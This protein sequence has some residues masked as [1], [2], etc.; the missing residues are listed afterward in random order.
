LLPEERFDVLINHRGPD[1]KEGFVKKLDESLRSA[2]IRAFVDANDIDFGHECWDSIRKAIRGAPVCICVFSPRYAESKWCLEELAFILDL[3]K[4]N[5]RKSVLPVF[6]N[7]EPKHLRRPDDSP[8]SEG[9]KKLIELKDISRWRN[10]L[11][12]SADFFGVE[13]ITTGI[14][15]GL[16]RQNPSILLFNCMLRKCAKT[17]HKLPLKRWSHKSH[18]WGVAYAMFF[19]MW[20]R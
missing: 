3:R 13:L 18:V 12:K 1:V 9:M 2:G 17:L 11:A 20:E 4:Q 5:P 15:V 6:Y 10:A 19:V 8:F 14:S 16:L 7:V